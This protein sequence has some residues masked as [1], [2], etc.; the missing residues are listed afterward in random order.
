LLDEVLQGTNS[1]ERCIGAKAVVLHLVARGAIGAVSSH[2]LGLA[3]LETESGGRVRNAHFEELVE[4][5]R[6]TFDYV[7]KPGVVR[8]TNALR[9]MKLVGLA[10]DLPDS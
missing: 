9:V 3:D 8:T 4:G 5:G 1:R 7:L 6:M 10:V 2:D